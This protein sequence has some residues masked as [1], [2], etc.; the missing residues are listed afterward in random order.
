MEELETLRK[1]IFSLHEEH[2]LWMAGIEKQNGMVQSRMQNVASLQLEWCNFK[3]TLQ[4]SP[5]R[6]LISSTACPDDDC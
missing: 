5:T 4:I 2:R 1:E 6:K 3:Y